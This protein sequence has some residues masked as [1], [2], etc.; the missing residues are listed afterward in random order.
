MVVATMQG[1]VEMFLGMLERPKKISKDYLKNA[2]FERFAFINDRTIENHVQ[3]LIS[4]LFIKP[5]APGYFL[6]NWG[7]ILRL[8]L[9]KGWGIKEEIEKEL[10]LLPKTEETLIAQEAKQ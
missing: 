10:Q 3:R 2:L 9:T 6:V 1:Y 5:V 4:L 7:G 8:A